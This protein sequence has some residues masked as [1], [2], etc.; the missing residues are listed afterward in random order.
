MKKTNRVLFASLSMALIFCVFGQHLA[1]VLDDYVV[2]W[3]PLY[4]L[5]GLTVFGWCL[6][7]LSLFVFIFRLIRRPKTNDTPS[8]ESVFVLSFMLVGAAIPWSVFVLAMW[9]G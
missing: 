8:Q 2:N 7:T 6:Y 3:H 5:T 9:W 1:Y 4:Y